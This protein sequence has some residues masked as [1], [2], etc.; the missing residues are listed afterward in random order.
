MIV[1][2]VVVVV[3]AVQRATVRV[4]VL[5]LMTVPGQAVVVVAV[6]VGH[7]EI[8]AGR[9]PGG[10]ERA[11]AGFGPG[12]SHASVPGGPII[13]CIAPGTLGV[14]YQV[15]AQL[16]VHGARARLFARNACAAQRDLAL[17]A[18]VGQARGDLAIDD[19]DHAAHGTAAI[20]QRGRPAQHLDA[21]D[22]QRIDGDCMIGRDVGSIEHRSAVGEHLDAWR[23]LAA[24]DRTAGTGTEG[25]LAHA[26]QVGDGLTQRPGAALHHH[27]P[28]DDAD[29]CRN[30]I[31]ALGDGAHRHFFQHDGRASFRVRV[32][33]RHLC[34]GRMDQ[35]DGRDQ[36]QCADLWWHEL[37]FRIIEHEYKCYI[38]TF[39]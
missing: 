16:L 15:L 5:E 3:A 34:P 29:R 21:P 33:S 27:F 39:M 31:G 10:T 28:V 8:A 14:Q 22:Q 7:A 35:Q 6:T 26:G 32:R 37:S 25:V 24:D 1:V 9:D 11:I 23:R 19:V 2:V 12:G 4:T 18:V 20:Q 36:H 13:G 38:I 17:Q 30:A